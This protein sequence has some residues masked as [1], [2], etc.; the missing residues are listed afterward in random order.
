MNQFKLWYHQALLWFTETRLYHNLPSIKA[1]TTFDYIRGGSL[2]LVGSGSCQFKSG[3]MLELLTAFI[4]NNTRHWWSTD[5]RKRHYV[6]LHTDN[7]MAMMERLIKMLGTNPVWAKH[8]KDIPSEEIGK[9]LNRFGISVTF[10]H[11]FEAKFLDYQLLKDH[12]DGILKAGDRIDGIF[13]DDLIR[14][15][16]NNVHRDALKLLRRIRSEILASTKAVMV[17]ASNLSLRSHDGSWVDDRHFCS[18]TQEVDIGFQ[19]SIIRQPAIPILNGE[20]PP[21]PPI[22]QLDLV[23]YRGLVHK[24]PRMQLSFK[25]HL[26]VLKQHPVPAEA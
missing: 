24:N 19:T 16:D 13:V 9:V 12:V 11:I 15:S 23:K 2:V 25:D 4:V 1:L 26:K 7:Q 6:L 17:S 21:P 5:R 18:A 3:F 20:I 10:W 14:V 22:L 8:L